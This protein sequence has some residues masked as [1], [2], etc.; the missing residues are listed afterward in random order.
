MLDRLYKLSGRKKETKVFE[1]YDIET[2]NDKKTLKTI[3]EAL[4]CDDK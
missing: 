2:I 4:T 3:K 1:A